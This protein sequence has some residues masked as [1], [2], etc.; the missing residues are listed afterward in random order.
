MFVVAGI[1]NVA[2]NFYNTTNK[3]RLSA[4]DITTTQ[5]ESDPLNEM[6]G[7]KQKNNNRIESIESKLQEL[8]GLRS[9][10]ACFRFGICIA[11]TAHSE[12]HLR[13]MVLFLKA[14]LDDRKKISMRKAIGCLTPRGKITRF[15]A[16]D[17]SIAE[18]L[19]CSQRYFLRA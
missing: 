2:Y 5:E 7:A 1:A 17:S 10:G 3:Q 15:V 4:F 6:F 9:K 13:P 18:G 16:V 11:T 14:T 12:F 8:D 19:F